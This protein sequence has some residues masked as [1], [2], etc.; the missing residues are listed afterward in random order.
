MNWTDMHYVHLEADEYK[1]Y[2][3]KTAVLSI[4]VR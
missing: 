3:N 2:L 4:C 1:T